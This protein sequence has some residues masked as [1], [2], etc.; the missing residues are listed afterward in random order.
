M[1]MHS[2][3]IS[4]FTP[5]LFELRIGQLAMR[6]GR[7]MAD[8]RF[9]VADI[10]QALEQPERVME[11]LARLET[12][13]DAE[14]EE[15]G[16]ASAQIFLR[17]RVVGIVHMAGIAAPFDARMRPQER[18]DPRRVLDVALHA[19]RQ[20]LDALQQHE[21]AHRR[22]HRASV[23]LA[24]GAAA[25]DVGASAV[26]LGVDDAVIGVLRLGQHREAFG[27]RGPVEAAAVDDGTAH[28]RAVAAEELGQRMHDDVGAVGEGLEQHRRRD[29]VIDDQR[30]AVAVRDLRQRLDV[31][32]VAGRVADALA[33]D[34]AGVRVDQRLD[35]LRRVARGEAE[36]DALLAQ[37]GIEQGVGRPHTASAGSR[38]S[39]R[40]RRC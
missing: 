30:H 24:D 33:I 9:A 28:G 6:G 2:R 4:G 29:G 10:E 27:V 17:Q 12:A 5:A 39:S 8:E 40:P 35:V 13:F 20:R 36:V 22:E 18:C 1:P 25:R 31:G 11:T 16:P 7:G 19:Q 21:R 38:C 23:A 3:I 14:G 34:R 26:L 15:R 37:E 32:D